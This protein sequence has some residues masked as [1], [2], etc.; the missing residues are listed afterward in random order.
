MATAA[1]S[2][3]QKK[4][5]P[6]T[7]GYSKTKLQE[8][9]FT[10]GMKEGDEK[11][12]YKIVGVIS[13]YRIGSSDFGAWT[14]FIGEFQAIDELTGEVHVGSAALFPQFLSD[15]IMGKLGAMEGT[16]AIEF[17]AQIG[18]Q[19]QEDSATGYVFTARPLVEFTQS[20]RMQ[21][22]LKAAGIAAALPAPAAQGANADRGGNGEGDTATVSGTASDVA[23]L[24]PPDKGA[25]A[26]KSARR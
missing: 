18:F 16:Q 5:T 7:L 13:S 17:A 11:P 10:S 25:K 22:L 4:L 15:M 12:L 2:Q 8:L 14:K 9:M 6:K 1:K 23:K 26:G 20:N 19:R 21:A 3:L 24:P